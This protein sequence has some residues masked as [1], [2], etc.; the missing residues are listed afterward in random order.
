MEGIYF[1]ENEDHNNVHVVV[2]KGEY[3][4]AKDAHVASIAYLKRPLKETIEQL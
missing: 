4:L 2:E 3:K 1:C